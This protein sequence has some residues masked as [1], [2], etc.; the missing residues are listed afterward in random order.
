MTDTKVTE[1]FTQK[2]HP[3]LFE[4]VGVKSHQIDISWVE[5]IG[6]WS[7][8]WSQFKK[9]KIAMFGLRCIVVLIFI[10]IMAP[11]IT[12]DK[13]FFCYVEGEG[14][15]LPWFKAL[16]DRNFFENGVDIFFNLLIILAPIYFLFIWFIK[17]KLGKAFTIYFLNILAVFIV[18]HLFI[19]GLVNTLGRYGISA[20]R[21]SVV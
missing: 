16:F 7:I 1:N 11:L 21:K 8:V 13:P 2:T 12:L 18:I 14:I 5:K 10:A 4:K 9:N 20:D 19:F 17:R 6:F 15:Y 3:E